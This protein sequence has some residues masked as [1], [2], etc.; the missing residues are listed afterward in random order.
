M[1]SSHRRPVAGRA[2]CVDFTTMSSNL[3]ESGVLNDTGYS[4]LQCLFV[5]E[6]YRNAIVAKTLALAPEALEKEDD[7]FHTGTI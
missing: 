7:I 2:K 4:F 1:A 5:W 6:K 3:C